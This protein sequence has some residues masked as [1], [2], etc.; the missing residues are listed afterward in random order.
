MRV[1]F[2]QCTPVPLRSSLPRHVVETAYERG[3]ESL[4]NGELLG[5]AEAAGFELLVTTDQ[6][7]RYQQNLAKRKMRVLA[8]RTANWPK[9][10][11]HV[12]MIARAIDELALGKY[13]EISFPS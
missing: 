9:I 10:K 13:R 4:T 6:G 5:A 11:K 7:L 8:L 12:E 1:L 3:W 2:D